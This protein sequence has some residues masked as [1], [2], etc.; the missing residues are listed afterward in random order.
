MQSKVWFI[1]GTSKWFGYV[2]TKAALARGDKVA[3]AGRETAP[4]TKL[5]ARY[6]ENV[7]PMRIDPTDM[8]ALD[9]AVARAEDYFSRIDAF[10]TDDAAVAADVAELGINVTL[11]VDGNSGDA[12]TILDHVDR[13]DEPLRERWSPL[14][15]LAHGAV[16]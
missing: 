6:G 15:Q 3:A 14:P 4:L 7:L 12:R 1:T 11:V 5:A 13:D 8:A 10:V 16:A 9:A 2:W